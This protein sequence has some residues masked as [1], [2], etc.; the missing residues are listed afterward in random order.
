[1][2]SSSFYA[3]FFTHKARLLNFISLGILIISFAGLS[4]LQLQFDV[5]SWFQTSDPLLIQYSRYQEM[6]GHDESINLLYSREDGFLN[7]EAITSLRNLTT[8]LWSLP[9][10]QEVKS[11]ATPICHILR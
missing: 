10:I 5:K 4:R 11:L 9:H 6:F 7:K 3:Q 2:T 1:M 8:R